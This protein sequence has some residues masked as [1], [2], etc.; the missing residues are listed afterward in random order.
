MKWQTLLIPSRGKKLLW[1]LFLYSAKA[2]VLSP[3]WNWK[4][5]HFGKSLEKK[6]LIKHLLPALQFTSNSWLSVVGTSTA[7]A[8]LQWPKP[9]RSLRILK[10]GPGFR[11]HKEKS[12]VNNYGHSLARGALQDVIQRW[13]LTNLDRGGSYP[14]IP[15]STFGHCL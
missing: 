11:H 4:T 9:W 13:T 6:I 8:T 10:Y 12:V 3:F 2:T 14:A 7:P 5:F 15:T 1:F